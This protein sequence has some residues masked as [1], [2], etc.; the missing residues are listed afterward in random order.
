MYL[1]KTTRYILNA[2]PVINPE[3]VILYTPQ[4]GY[5]LAFAGNLN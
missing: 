1:Q 5:P 3:V 4:N 2:I